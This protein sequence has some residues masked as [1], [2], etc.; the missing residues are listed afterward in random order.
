[1]LWERRSAAADAPARLFRLR[2]FAF[3]NLETLTVYAGLSTLSFFLVLFLQ[4][5]AGYS[6]LQSGL[7]TLPDHG[8]DVLPLA[9][10]RAALDA[11]R[12]A[13]RSWASGRSS[14]PPPALAARALARVRLLDGAPSAVLLFAFGLSMIVAP[15]T[16]TVLADAGPSD[17][18]IASGVNNAIARIAGLLGIAVVGAAIAGTGNK[19]DLSGYRTRWRSPRRSRAGGVD[20]PRRDPEPRSID[21]RRRLPPRSSSTASQ[22]LR[23]AR[24]RR[25]RR[26]LAHDPGRHV[27]RPRRPVGRRQDDGAQARQ[28][29]DPVR[30]GRH[31]DRRPQHQGAPG[32]R[33][34]PRDR[35]RD[36]AGRAVPAHDDRREHRHRAAAARLAEAAHRASAPPSCS[37]SSA[38]SRPTRSAIR[39]SSRAASASASGSPA[40]SPPTRRVLLMDEPFG[41]LDP[42]TRARL[43]ESC[44]GCTGRSRRR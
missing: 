42:I 1:M 32:G 31:P 44:G 43:Q 29:A 16:A 41:A 28:Q 34:P 7:A 23:G 13:A 15:L 9:P 11:V 18:G 6:P 4:Q 12:A 33:A 17:A 10:R 26:A 35:L 2:N 30:R 8:R 14:A 38:S 27:L 39:R 21:G 37:S 36:P 40:R 19:L 25:A 22:A 20:R 24:R 3:A 5:L